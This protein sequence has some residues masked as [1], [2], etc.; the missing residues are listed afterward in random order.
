MQTDPRDALHHAYRAVGK[1]GRLQI[2]AAAAGA[3]VLNS[4]FTEP[5]LTKFIQDVQ[6]WLPIALLKSKLWSSNPFWNANVMNEDRRQIAGESRRTA[7]V[8][9]PPPP[10]IAN[11]GTRF[12]AGVYSAIAWWGRHLE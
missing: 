5:N 9:Y 8:A 7:A 10:M 12:G 4:G 1:P 6:K 3:Y 2:P 11:Q